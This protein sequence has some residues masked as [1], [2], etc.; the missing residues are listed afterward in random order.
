MLHV[1]YQ[2][3]QKIGR[4]YI[5]WV[6]LNEYSWT[7]LRKNCPY[8]ELFCIFSHSYW[9]RRDTQSKCGK[10]WTRITPNTNTFPAV[11]SMLLCLPCYIFLLLDHNKIASFLLKQNQSKA[12]NNASEI[13]SK[14][15]PVKTN[16]LAQEK[17]TP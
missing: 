9:I 12:R 11:S 14:N 13:S 17:V 10:M 1:L 3:S 8:S 4:G 6:Y 2:I 7:P 16:I 5:I 15:V